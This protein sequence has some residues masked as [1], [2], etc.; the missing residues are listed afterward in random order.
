MQLEISLDLILKKKK[1]A[2]FV[3]ILITYNSIIGFIDCQLKKEI[4]QL[5]VFFV[6][7]SNMGGYY[8]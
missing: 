3:E 5:Y 4:F 1:N 6:M 7:E 8:K 2:E